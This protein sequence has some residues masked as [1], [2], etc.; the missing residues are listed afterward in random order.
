MLL[1]A[2]VEGV[3]VSVYAK[4]EQGRYL[5]INPAAARVLGRTAAEVLGRVDADLFPP[6]SA[7]QIIESMPGS[8]PRD[9]S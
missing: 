6:D 3:D 1:R 5:L 9:G 7:R 2:V 8:W 4:D